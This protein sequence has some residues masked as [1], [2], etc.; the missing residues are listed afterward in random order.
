MIET[1][2]FVNK[3]KPLYE[4]TLTKSKQSCIIFN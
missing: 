1:Y 4:Y 3:K 2:D